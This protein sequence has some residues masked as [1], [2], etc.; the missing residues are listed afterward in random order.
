MSLTANLRVNRCASGQLLAHLCIGLIDPFFYLPENS[1][2]SIFL[3]AALC[4]WIREE[5]YDLYENQQA[6]LPL[7]FTLTAIKRQV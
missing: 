2:V 4:D 1:A 7:C 6:Q 5:K 3:C